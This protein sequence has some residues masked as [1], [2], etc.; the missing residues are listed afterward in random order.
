MIQFVDPCSFI[1]L[2]SSPVSVCYLFVSLATLQFCLL[3]VFIF[4]FFND[5]ATTE[6][7]TLHIVGS[8]RCVQETGINAEYMGLGLL[9]HNGAG[10]STIINI[11]TGQ[12]SL[13]KGSVQ[14]YGYDIQQ[15]IGDIR[16]ILGVCPQFDILWNEL[17]AEE[18]LKMFCQLK[19]IPKEQI[20]REIAIR[21]AEVSL[22]HVKKQQIRTYSG[23]MKRRISLAIS[24]IGDP[25]IILLDEPTS[26]LDPKTKNQIWRMIQQLKQK[27]SMI[28]T[29][30]S[31]EEAEA[32]SDR[33]TIINQG[34]VRCIGTPIFLK[35]NY[36]DGYR[37][38]IICNSQCMEQVRSQLRELMHSSK[39]VGESGD[40][41][42][43][44][45][46][47]DK[48]QEIK[49]F[50]KVMESQKASELKSMILE[51]GIS[52]TTLEEIFLKITN[53]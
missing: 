12:L 33:I 7:Y 26:G 49:T 2:S 4:F 34:E 52:H 39:V 50:F 53:S 13:S 3:F 30:H 15:S 28:L 11:L 22:S 16:Q 44:T 41:L 32:L 5:T 21:M 14:I 17:T 47:L 1:W 35:T 27:R 42:I 10:K 43:I 8:V 18:H 45:V 37:L 29:T 31:M 23:G 25:K 46:P 48:N 19:K 36:G 38:T 20:D 24:S 51:W 6:I 9:G 40:R